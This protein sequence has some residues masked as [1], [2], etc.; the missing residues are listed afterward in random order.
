MLEL[1]SKKRFV[2]IFKDCPFDGDWKNCY[3]KEN[4]IE[5]GYLK[6]S[7]KFIILKNLSIK[8]PY[9]KFLKVIDSPNSSFENLLLI[10][11][12]VL[13]ISY[14]PHSIEQFAFQKNVFWRR[15][16]DVKTQKQ[17]YFAFKL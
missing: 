1:Y 9:D 3:L 17:K 4:E 6:K 2:V 5:L 13:K 15:F 16:F 12:N 14:D 7:G 11:P 8:F 10:S